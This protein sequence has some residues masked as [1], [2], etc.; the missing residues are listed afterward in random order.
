MKLTAKV[1]VLER[2]LRYFN[3]FGFYGK[4]MYNNN[5]FQLWRMF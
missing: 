2:N 5:Y 1:Q 4:M 3:L